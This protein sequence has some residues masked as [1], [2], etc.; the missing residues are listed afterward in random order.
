ML[1][2]LGLFCLSLILPFLLFTKPVL[3][4][5][6]T[7]SIDSEHQ[8]LTYD[9]NGPITLT[10]CFQTPVNYT[11]YVYPRSTGIVLLGGGLRNPLDTSEVYYTNATATNNTTLVVNTNLNAG[12]QYVGANYKN[13]PWSISVC[14]RD[15]SSC[16]AGIG[17]LGTA[18]FQVT[19]QQQ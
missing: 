2:K 9:F 6:C 16:L 11:V 19:G 7:L 12:G 15:R 13:Q 5:D 14:S 18:T 4:Q 3:A 17:I 10:G 1:T 8:N